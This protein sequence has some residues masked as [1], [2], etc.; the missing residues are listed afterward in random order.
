M[1]IAI[2]SVEAFLPKGSGIKYF[3]RS[4][5]TA[6]RR[7]RQAVDIVLEGSRADAKGSD[8]AGSSLF[9]IFKEISPVGKIKLKLKARLSA[10]PPWRFRSRRLQEIS[11]QEHDSLFSLAATRIPGGKGLPIGRFLAANQVFALAKEQFLSRGVFT[12]IRIPERHKANQHS[13]VDTVFH[14]PLP[15]PLIASN[16]PTVTTVHD[17]IPL[18]HPELCLDNPD[19]FYRLLNQV[20]T[21]SAAVHAISKY[22]ANALLDIFGNSVSSKLWIAPQAVLIEPSA[23]RSSHECTAI[24]ENLYHRLQSGKDVYIIQVGSIEPKKNHSTSIAAFKEIRS[25]YPNLRF[26]IVGKNGWL[27]DSL[28]DYMIASKSDG[29]EWIGSASRGL[30]ESYIRQSMALIF[31]SLVEGW[32]LPPLEAMALGCPVISSSIEACRESCGNAA[33]F[34]EDSTSVEE[35]RDRLLDVLRNPEI[36]FSL[37]QKGLTRAK[38]YSLRRFGQD[39]IEIY[40]TVSMK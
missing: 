38:D 14:N 23:Q 32:G 6:L 35:L 8:L 19:T 9:S 33:L 11:S 1:R 25:I 36:G 31:P 22:T 26:M 4:L 28:C 16:I 10:L 39:M 5:I 12:V 29:I 15:F 20:V 3:S 18:S 21:K 27:S 30:L 17:L 40:K 2:N 37:S 7:E 34:I 24:R 13:Q